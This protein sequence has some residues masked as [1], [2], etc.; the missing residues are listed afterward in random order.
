MDDQIKKVNSL[1]ENFDEPLSDPAYLAKG[2]ISEIAKN[3]DFKV[4]ISGDGG[5]E[6]F[7]GYEPFLKLNIYNN[8]KR[9]KFLK[10]LINIYNKF[11]NDS[12]GYMGFNYKLR[13]FSKGFISNDDYFNSRWLCAFTPEEIK[14][15]I[16]FNNYENIDSNNL[17]IYGYIQKIINSL[18]TNS[19][20]Y[21]KLLAQYQNHYLP[22]LICSHTDKGNMMHS[23]EARSPFLYKDLFEFTNSVNKNLKYKNG[24]SKIVLRNLLNKNNFRHIGKAKK[25]VYCSNCY[26]D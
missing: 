6:L 21:V 2:M 8:I 14:E 10:N 18:K 17:N 20:D 16:N 15:I 23:I 24:K 1:I 12:F 9:S 3:Y 7:G 22:N 26:M 19:D 11:S 25:R 5:D 13:V 4:M